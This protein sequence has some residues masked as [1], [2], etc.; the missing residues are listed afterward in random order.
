VC[1]L[2]VRPVAER[3]YMTDG[4]VEPAAV[5]HPAAART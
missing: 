2:L 3:H 4:E 1:N 5:P